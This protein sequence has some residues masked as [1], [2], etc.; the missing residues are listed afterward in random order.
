MGMYF[1]T[2]S[3]R[4]ILPSST[5]IMTNA[6]VSHLLQLAMGAW[7]FAIEISHFFFVNQ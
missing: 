4:D 1:T 3:S 2:G 7:V 5:N 6:A